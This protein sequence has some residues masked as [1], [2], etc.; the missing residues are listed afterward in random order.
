[1]LKRISIAALFCMTLSATGLVIAQKIAKDLDD[2]INTASNWAGWKPEDTFYPK[3]DGKKA[4][5]DG[6]ACV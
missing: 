2:A 5:E 3:E 4:L 6:K 1:M